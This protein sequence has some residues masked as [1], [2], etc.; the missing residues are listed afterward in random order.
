[1][2]ADWRM[3]SLPNSGVNAPRRK[4]FCITEPLVFDD[5]DFHSS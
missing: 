1:M 3:L 5:K 4:D 2:L